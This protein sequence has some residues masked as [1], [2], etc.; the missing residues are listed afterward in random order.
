MAKDRRSS[1]LTEQG[2]TLADFSAPRQP[3]DIQGRRGEWIPTWLRMTRTLP[4]AIYCLVFAAALEALNRAISKQQGLPV[5]PEHRYSVDAARY[6]P[7]IGVVGLGFACKS[8]ASDAKKVTPWSAISYKW[9]ESEHSIALDYS[10]SIEILS[11]IPA[12]KRKHWSV[13]VGLVVGLTCGILVS[14]ANALTVVNSS[15]S[16]WEPAT[17]NRATIFN[18]S[19]A[20]EESDQSLA[21]P[22][23]FEGQRPYA[24]VVAE[25]LPNGQAAAWTKDSYVFESFINRTKMPENGTMEARTK[26]F[27]PGWSCHSINMTLLYQDVQYWGFDYSAR[28]SEQPGLNCSR[29]MEIEFVKTPGQ[30]FGALNVTACGDDETDLWLLSTLVGPTKADQ[31]GKSSN[32]TIVSAMC[33]PAFTTQDA[34]VRVNQSSGEVLDYTLG[35]SAPTP[36]DIQTSM[37]AIY[38]YLNNP[39]DGRSQE[40]FGSNNLGWKSDE[41]P[42]ANLSVVATARKLF[43]SDHNLDPFTSSI[44]DNNANLTAETFLHNPQR[45]TAAVEQQA[46]SIMAQI[47]NF[48]ARANTT[49]SLDGRVWML[50]PKLL[51]RQINLRILQ[52]SLIT[53]GLCCVFQSAVFR[54]KTVLREDPGSIAAQGVVLASSTQGIE[55]VFAKEAVSSEE[56]MQHALMTKVWNLQQNAKGSVM[57]AT[58]ERKDSANTFPSQ[59]TGMH[60]HVGFRPFALQV[61][62][63]WVVVLAI[64]VVM[65]ALAALMIVSHSNHGICTSAGIA[66]NAF[67]F[68]S[69][70]TFT[71]L[72]YGCSG[73]DAAVRV[74]TPYKSLW[75]G[76]SGQKRPLLFNFGEAPNVLAPLH[77][78]RKHLGPT[79]AAS[80]FVVLFVPAIKIVAAGLYGKKN[81]PRI[82]EI[83]PLI[84]LSFVKNLEDTFGLPQ[85]IQNVTTARKEAS[86]KMDLAANVQIAS[87]FTEWT[88]HQN[89]NIPVQAGILDNLVFRNLTSIGEVHTADGDISRGEI[90]VNIPA[91]M[92]DVS[93]TSENLSISMENVN[94]CFSITGYCKT[95]ACN[96]TIKP[97]TLKDVYTW[98]YASEFNLGCQNNRYKGETWILPDLRY[99]IVLVDSGSARNELTNASSVADVFNSSTIP[100]MVAAVCYSNFSQVNVTTTFSRRISSSSSSSTTIENTN[101]SSWHPIRYN[102][103]TVKRTKIISSIPYWLEPLARVTSWTSPSHYDGVTEMPGLLDSSSL[104]PTRGSSTSMFELLAGYASTHGDGNLQNLMNQ[105]FLKEAAESVYT[106]FA[107][108]MLT[109]LRPLAAHESGDAKPTRFK[110]KITFPRE[111]V[112]QDLSSTIAIEVLL[113]LM[114]LCFV[115]VALR[116]PNE[117]ILPKN[118]GSIAAMATLLAGSKFVERLRAEGVTTTAEAGEVMKGQAALGWWPISGK[119]LTADENNSCDCNG[120]QSE[121]QGLEEAGGSHQSDRDEAPKEEQLGNLDDIGERSDGETLASAEYGKNQGSDRERQLDEVHVS[122]RVN[123]EEEMLIEY[124]AD[125]ADIG[126]KSHVRWGIDVGAGV[127]RKSWREPPGGGSSPSCV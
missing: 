102:S 12:A 96:S 123:D 13:F 125:E 2:Y 46:K 15:A 69:T 64:L 41:K 47:T 76:Y 50:G 27:L 77:A 127:I 33:A 44:V 112:H 8:I 38:I 56:H 60:N 100:T 29:D 57:L 70:S 20:L 107:T 22:Y 80:S 59:S 53:I 92:V 83:Q 90:T 45:F 1:Q 11:V 113:G 126:D 73:I 32:T 119:S 111:R 35:L 101:A 9:S 10:S 18:F 7:T 54:P 91:I 120:E 88:M 109:Q 28:T 122:E 89:F 65:A 105:D 19:G 86:P 30:I 104:W 99:E 71:I 55:R 116:F 114:A 26:A 117:A 4:L 49:G 31:N 17:F 21:I 6:I 66:L 42:H 97:M 58:Q 108:N 51:L 68:L 95:S 62:A 81:F 61:W 63:K 67:T 85:D 39:L 3:H 110:G 78:I 23:T 82:A 75:S 87:Q 5:D 48:L 72:G 16:S 14:V 37:A 24:A 103:S 121:Q 106:S 52:A 118:P 43:E 79:I 25:Q 40:V 98:V 115:W 124:E 74:M 84:D 93:C 34:L 94:N 36:I